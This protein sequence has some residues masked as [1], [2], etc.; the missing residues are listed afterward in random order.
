MK[1]CMSCM[2]ETESYPCPHC[3]YIPQAQPSYALNMGTL[4]MNR[5]MVGKLLGQ[6]G[7]GITYVGWDIQENKKVAIKE[8]YPSGQV[9]REG[10]T[11]SQLR[12]NMTQQADAMRRSGTESFLKEALKMQKLD[13][14]PE[15]THVYTAFHENDTAYIVMEFVEGETL[16]DYLMSTGPL[17]WE[18]AK[19]Y[20]LPVILAMDKVHEANIIHRD[21]SPDNLM[22][23]RDGGIKILD[24]GAAK[25]LNVNTGASSMLVAKGGFSPLEQYS[26]RGGSGPW[27]DVYALAATI[28]YTITG[29]VPPV[30]MDR[31]EYE[32]LRWDLPELSQV[33]DYV[34]RGLQ[35]A[36]VI[37]PDRRTRS[38]A[39]L[40]DDLEGCRIRLIQEEQLR[41]ERE[42][43]ARKLREEKKRKTRKL[44]GILIPVVAAV[45][46]LAIL[47]PTVIVP[48][49][50][51]GKAY[52]QAQTLLENG[53]FDSAQAIFRNLGTW[54]DA[55][56]MVLECGYRKAEAALRNLRYDDAISL[57][58]SLGGY[59]D[60][61]ERSENAYERKM[62]ALY[63]N[64]ARL[65]EQGSFAE[66]R[67]A[68]AAL[69]GWSDSADR[70]E[71]CAQL[72]N[73]GIYDEAI[74]LASQGAY[75][76]AI[77][78][79]E[80]LGSFS[81]SADQV[82]QL[83]YIYAASLYE[84]ADYETA[85]KYYKKAGSYE[86]SQSRITEC[87]FG[88]GCQQVENRKY[89]DAITS[90]GN[91]SDHADVDSW[92]CAAKLGYASTHASRDNTRTAKYLQELLEK[93]YPG[94]SDLHE[95]IFGWKAVVDGFNNNPYS[96]EP[97]QTISKYNTIYCHF[98][99]T[100]GMEGEKV[101]IRTELVSPAGQVL[102]QKIDDV[103]DG[104]KPW[105]SFFYFNPAT[106]PAGTMTVRIYV[107]STNKLLATGSVPITN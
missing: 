91:C 52:S 13:S 12:W 8:Y 17:S 93:K 66:A 88:L 68:F 20:F 27:T 36:L 41:Q 62:N 34:I 24:L 74:A 100:G 58:D 16:R 43:Q 101:R 72:H 70:A 25:D 9:I 103:M 4:L 45:L 96:S 7:F 80:Q 57:W 64:A 53:D 85:L 77:D 28:Y 63:D 86:D 106:S 89:D 5:Y 105:V 40:Y 71:K 18:R 61:A 51:N 22:I 1:L 65:M 73:Q 99:I 47:T 29:V 76:E 26:Q 23:T 42:A 38:M 107:D 35:K 49:V 54:S 94:A 50:K 75:A 21:L 32:S 95:Q 11:S 104:N 37:Y 14:V 97:M 19:E 59:R 15:A 87:W 44:L 60:S 102:I 78:S 10:Q 92:L 83:S 30:V 56:D 48:A 90:F 6:G 82:V 46:A 69:G 79:L 2:G 3:G 55:S 39:Q 98:T 81:D 31:M 33:P 84:A 67:D